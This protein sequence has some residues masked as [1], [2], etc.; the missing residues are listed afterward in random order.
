MLVF[1]NPFSSG[2]P[3]IGS[4]GQTLTPTPAA[5]QEISSI[6]NLYSGS[7][8]VYSGVGRMSGAIA[9]FFGVNLNSSPGMG[10]SVRC[11]KD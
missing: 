6:T 2:Y 11:L 3:S 4:F 8:G 9:N 7:Y 1:R 10:F 5:V